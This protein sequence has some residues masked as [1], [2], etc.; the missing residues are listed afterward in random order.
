MF[1]WHCQIDH[2]CKF[3]LNYSEGRKS[4]QTFCLIRIIHSETERFGKR[5]RLLHQ[6]SSYLWRLRNWV[7][8]SLQD[9]IAC[10]QYDHTWRRGD[11]NSLQAHNTMQ[12]LWQLLNGESFQQW[13][14]YT[15][16]WSI[17]FW[18][19]GQ[20]LRTTP[21]ERKRKKNLID[22]SIY[23]FWFFFLF[24]LPVCVCVRLRY[25]FVKEQLSFRQLLPL[26]VNS[27][28]AFTQHLMIMSIVIPE[29]WG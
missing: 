6:F 5:N 23:V 12:Y 20:C 1:L 17:L 29:V 10:K 26:K 8:R 3:I 25:L 22:K 2:T 27:I 7:R 19:L 28:D 13:L 24:C 18:I 4:V 14:Y 11:A 16:L 21:P 9:R 15:R